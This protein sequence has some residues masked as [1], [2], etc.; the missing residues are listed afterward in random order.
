LKYADA[1]MTLDVGV[2]GHDL[3][4]FVCFPCSVDVCWNGGRI[5]L[6]CASVGLTCGLCTFLEQSMVNM[7]LLLGSV[8]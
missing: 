2:Q 6:H 8:F 3:S 1:I 4:L 7:W 5:S